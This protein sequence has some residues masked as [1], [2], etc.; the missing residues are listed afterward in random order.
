MIRSARGGN[1]IIFLTAVAA[2]PS[3]GFT[4]FWHSRP[5]LHFGT[6]PKLLKWWSGM[7]VPPRIPHGRSNDECFVGFLSGNLEVSANGQGN[8]DGSAWKEG[9]RKSGGGLELAFK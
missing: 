5:L 3:V 4:L 9:V 2:S 7:E 6:M 1:R 8:G